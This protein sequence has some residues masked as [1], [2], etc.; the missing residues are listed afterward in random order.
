MV[1]EIALCAGAP[2]AQW[3]KELKAFLQQGGGE[4]QMSVLGS[5]K[6]PEGI[7]KTTRLKAF[8]QARPKSF[9]VSGDNKVSLK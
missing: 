9:V 3:E 1:C 7:A 5:V 6:K 8:L 2:E 4:A